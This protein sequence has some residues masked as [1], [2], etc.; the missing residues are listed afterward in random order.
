MLVS[1]VV[2]GGGGGSSGG[3]VEVVERVVEGVGVCGLGVDDAN[4]VAVLVALDACLC[5]DGLGNGSNAKGSVALCLV[6]PLLGVLLELEDFLLS[7][8]GGC[9]ESRH[10]SEA[11]VVLRES[12]LLVPTESEQMSAMIP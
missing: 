2:L 9:F 3:V 11:S 7:A 1:R 12:L 8:A 4:D 10:K 6:G 5:D